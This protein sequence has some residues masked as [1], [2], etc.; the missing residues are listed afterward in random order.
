MT[1]ENFLTFFYTSLS[2]LGALL[3]LIPAYIAYKRNKNFWIWWICTVAVLSFFLLIIIQTQNISVAVYLLGIILIASIL[4]LIPARDLNIL[5]GSN[6]SVRWEALTGILIIGI[7]LYYFF[8]HAWSI[9]P[10]NEMSYLEAMAFVI[11]ISGLGLASF[12][13]VLYGKSI[14]DILII[15]LLNSMLLLF[16][17][18]QGWNIYQRIMQKLSLTSV[19]ELFDP[20]IK[21]LSVQPI[22]GVLILA[23][24]SSGCIAF[25]VWLNDLLGFVGK[26]VTLFQPNVPPD[27]PQTVFGLPIIRLSKNP[28]LSSYI[29]AGVLLLYFVRV[30][31]SATHIDGSTLILWPLAIFGLGGIYLF[32]VLWVALS[33][34]A[35]LIVNGFVV[36]VAASLIL[37]TTVIVLSIK[38][39]KVLAAIAVF[40]TGV[41]SV[42]A[43]GNNTSDPSLILK[44]YSFG[45]GFAALVL[46]VLSDHLLPRSNQDQKTYD[47]L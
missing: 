24:V 18:F 45:S 29:L 35:V 46:W 22:Y 34:V 14:R 23:A 33:V 10:A 40:V 21:D 12:I 8:I 15:I 28:F 4:A 44:S 17:L 25:I 1:Y 36:V 16:F 31:L 39:F 30:L 27:V 47:I 6:R 41:L 19:A 32:A 43:M 26:F 42:Y 37:S 38:Q 20:V 11:L 3:S 9:S 7:A 5:G 13:F 2:I